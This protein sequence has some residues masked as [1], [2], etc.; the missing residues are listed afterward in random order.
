MCVAFPGRVVAFDH[1]GAIVDTEGRQRRASTVLL[2]RVAIGDWV[3]VSAGTILERIDE[4]EAAELRSL[5]R[6]ATSGT[7]VER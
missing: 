2:P 1:D 7:G 4:A 6:L 3:V 5:V